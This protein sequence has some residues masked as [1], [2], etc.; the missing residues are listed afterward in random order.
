VFLS[1][2]NYEQRR[3]QVRGLPQAHATI[4]EGRSR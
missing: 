3:S 1:G 4:R 2:T